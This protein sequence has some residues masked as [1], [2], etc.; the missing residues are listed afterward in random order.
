MESNHP[1]FLTRGRVFEARY[2]PAMLSSK[3]LFIKM[4]EGLLAEGKAKQPHSPK[5]ILL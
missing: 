2:R 5:I 1:L 3:I 4:N